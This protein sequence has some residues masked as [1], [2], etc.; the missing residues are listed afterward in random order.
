MD[1]WAL[2]MENSQLILMVL[3]IL[4]AAIARYF[5]VKAGLLMEAAQALVALQQ[6]FLNT[7]RDGVITK[8]ELDVILQKIQAASLA[9]KAA[10]DAFIQPVPISEKI[11]MIFGGHSKLKAEVANVNAQVQSMKLSRLSRH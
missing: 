7:I 1:I 5:G 6:E 9:L 11:S 10:L 2:I 3:S 4:L 8:E